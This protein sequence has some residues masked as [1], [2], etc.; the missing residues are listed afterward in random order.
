MFNWSSHH[1]SVIFS[2]DLQFC[3]IKFIYKVTAIKFN[4]SKAL[5]YNN[6]LMQ[7][8][9]QLAAEVVPLNNGT[10]QKI[11]WAFIVYL[12]NFVIMKN[13]KEHA[14]EKSINIC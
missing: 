11:C 8:I 5:N 13:K 10:F 7:T 1:Y 3:N 2:E 12:L 6:I 14:N 4:T 9:I